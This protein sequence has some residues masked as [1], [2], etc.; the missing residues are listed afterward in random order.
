MQNRVDL[1]ARRVVNQLACF[2]RRH[3]DEFDSAALCLVDDFGH[4]RQPAIGARPD[5]ESSPMPGN[6]LGNRQRR[7]AVLVAVSLRRFF[8]TLAN[9]TRFDH[10]IRGETLAVDVEFAKLD[11]S[12]ACSYLSGISFKKRFRSLGH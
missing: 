9:L 8:L 1:G 6:P 10:H 7:M 12:R 5:D 2:A 4:N 11:K 3:S